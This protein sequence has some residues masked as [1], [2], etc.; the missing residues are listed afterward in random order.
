[1]NSLDADI[2]EISAAN[3]INIFSIITGIFSLFF[4][5]IVEVVDRK[6]VI[7]CI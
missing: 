7:I 3:K 5:D 1:M 4:G 2:T 6:I